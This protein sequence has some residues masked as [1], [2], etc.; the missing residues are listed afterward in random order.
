MSPRLPLR[1]LVAAVE[2]SAVGGRSAPII[3]DATIEDAKFIKLTDLVQVVESNAAPGIDIMSSTNE[4]RNHFF[5]KGG[6]ILSKGQGN[7]ESL[8]GVDIPEKD[9]YYLLKAKCNLMERIFDVKIGDLIF[10]KKEKS[11]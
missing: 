3:N 11:F 8:Y 2:T 7:F 1:R 6:I 9:V 5:R 4:F 10:K